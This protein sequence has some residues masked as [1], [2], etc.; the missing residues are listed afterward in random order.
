MF[1]QV[2]KASAGPEWF[3]IP[4][5]NLT[6]EFKRDFQVLQM[7]SLIDPKRHYKRENGKSKPPDFS[8]TGIILEG[9]TEFFSA[10]LS[11][12]ERRNNLL[13][14][15]LANETQSRTFTNKYQAIQARKSSGRK[16][17]YKAVQKKRMHKRN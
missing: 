9:P 5:T 10:R 12:R 15:V 14:D 1:V 6:S 8:Q 4:R 3:H 11:R 7:R 13:E 16:S 17:H 2:H